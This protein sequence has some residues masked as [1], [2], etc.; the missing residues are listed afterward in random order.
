MSLN[1]GLEEMPKIRPRESKGAS[2]STPWWSLGTNLIDSTGQILHIQTL[3]N[4]Q[5]KNTKGLELIGFTLSMRYLRADIWDIWSLIPKKHIRV[6]LP[7]SYIGPWEKFK[8][9]FFLL[10]PQLIY[11]P[12]YCHWDNIIAIFWLRKW[13]PRCLSDLSKFTKLK[14]SITR[15]WS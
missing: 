8:K 14:G 5:R 13:N 11:N 9:V 6:L 2:S 15:I 1:E 3:F 12:H 10:C 7:N 4:S